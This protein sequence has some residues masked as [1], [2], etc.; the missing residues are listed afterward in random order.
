MGPQTNVHLTGT[1]DLRNSGPIDVKLEGNTDAA[2][3]AL[4]DD[5]VKATGDTR[6]SVAAT[7]TVNQPKLDGFI[8]MQNGQAQLQEPRIAA[9][10]L[11]LRRTRWQPDSCGAIGRLYGWLD[12][13][14]ATLTCSAH[15]RVRQPDGDRRRN[16]L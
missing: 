5:T 13:R 14:Q 16:L 2:V 7:G 9:E 3:L 10:N 1:A 12:Q 15:S 4:F 11:Q 8:E 6:L